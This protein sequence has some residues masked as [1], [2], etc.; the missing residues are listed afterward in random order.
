MSF[1]QNLPEDV[2]GKQVFP[3]LRDEDY[4]QLLEVNREFSRLA[5]KY[6]KDFVFTQP[7]LEV[8]FEDKILLPH[9]RETDTDRYKEMKLF[10]GNV[11]SSD[12]SDETIITEPWMF[13]KNPETEYYFLWNTYIQS[14]RDSGYKLQLS[15]YRP[16]LGDINDVDDFAYGGQVK[17]KRNHRIGRMK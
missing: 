11:S 2:I 5:R 4:N 8:Q 6:E 17:Q 1:L 7:M 10:T 3:F 12:D 15:E 14:L 16:F 13:Y 9:L